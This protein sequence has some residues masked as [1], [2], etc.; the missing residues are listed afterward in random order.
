[1]ESEGGEGLSDGG[2]AGGRVVG[3]AKLHIFP[4]AAAA[5]TQLIID[6]VN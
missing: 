6:A 3:F 1:M 4:T 2:R 5:A